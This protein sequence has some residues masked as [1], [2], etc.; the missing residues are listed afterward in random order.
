MVHNMRIV[1][2]D[3]LGK[4]YFKI[5]GHWYLLEDEFLQLINTDAKEFYTKYKLQESI[6]NTWPIGTDEDYYNKSHNDRAT[7]FVF[8]KVISDN[9][10]LC[11]ILVITDEQ[12]YFV[13]VKDGFN[14]KMRD[15]YIQVVLSAKRL[16]NDLRD[17]KRSSFLDKTIK[18]YNKLNPSKKIK[19]EDLIE[20]LRDNSGMINFV[21]A[22]NN[23]HH[24]G[25]PILERLELCKSN[26]AKYSL[27]QV[28]KEMQQFRFSIKI[29]DISEINDK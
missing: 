17:N 1:R 10:E 9:I 11:D 29:I 6:L 24:K 26:I 20:K 18:K 19:S 27:V 4:K 2:I 3:Y 28:V 12:I 7:H 23:N 22:F 15:L 8:D 5:D 14:T 16:S 13:H 25:K 21:M